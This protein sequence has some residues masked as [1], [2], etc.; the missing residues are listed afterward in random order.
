MYKSIPTCAK[1]DGPTSEGFFWYQEL[2]T[3]KPEV[4]L[5]SR[6]DGGLTRWYYLRHSDN[7]VYAVEPNRGCWAH[8]FMVETL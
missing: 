3:S 2:P 7:C 4:V 6:R 5:V 1:L 8:C